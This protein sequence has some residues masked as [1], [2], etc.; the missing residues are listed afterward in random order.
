MATCPWCPGGCDGVDLTG[1]LTDDLTWLWSQLAAVGSRRDDPLLTSG[2]VTVTCP[3]SATE[4]AAALGLLGGKPLPP[5]GRRR[6]DLAAMTAALASVS[7]DLTPGVVAAHA[8][9]CR[10]TARSEARSRRVRDLS[11][12][13]SVLDEGLRSRPSYATANLDADTAWERLVR[14]G[15]VSRLLAPDVPSTLLRD[16]LAVLDRLPAPPGRVD[17]RTLVPGGPHD[18]DP[19]RPLAGLVLTL[20]GRSASRS[21]EAWAALGVDFDD[22]TGGLLALNIVPAGWTLPPGATVTLPPRELTGVTWPEPPAGGGW[23][24]VVENPSVVA[25]AA[26]TV[27]D[28]R[29]L[30]T[31][32][33][34]SGVEAAAV[35]RLAEAGWRVAV[36]ADFDPAGLAHVRALLA[37]CPSAVPWRMDA[38]TYRS[39][40]ANWGEGL[41]VV[42]EDSTPWDPTLA[43]AMS[44]HGAPVFEEDV[45]RHLLADLAAG[46]MPL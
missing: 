39:A 33:T 3:A 43:S 12:L 45:L 46:Q 13:R 30:C 18:L 17:R 38:A 10:L 5:G 23:V 1:L 14:S 25:A 2:T 16:A 26:D 34:P 44:A 7:P 11:Y 42:A 40:L 27:P 6:V 28:A 4:R 15:W 8:T 36:R 9:R 24:F 29:V 19:G 31:V 20:A 22:L 41:L 21:R 35:G 37:A 32:G